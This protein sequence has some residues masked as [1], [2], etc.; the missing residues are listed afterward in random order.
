[1]GFIK[2][3]IDKYGIMLGGGSLVILFLFFV[4]VAIFTRG[5]ILILIPIGIGVFVFLEMFDYYTDVRK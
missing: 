3:Y 4:L 1:M 5:A 2:W